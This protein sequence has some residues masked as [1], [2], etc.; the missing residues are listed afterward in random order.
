MAERDQ[1]CRGQQLG[2][3]H[4]LPGPVT[5]ITF[6]GPKEMHTAT[7]E[8]ASS[9]NHCAQSPKGP[10]RSAAAFDTNQGL[11]YGKTI[12]LQPQ[13]FLRE[14]LL[15]LIIINADYTSYI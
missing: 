1:I 10:Q 13:V 7:S 4:Q 8:E 12:S 3:P 6:F 5:S 2:K 9:C 11:R 14:Q 15:I